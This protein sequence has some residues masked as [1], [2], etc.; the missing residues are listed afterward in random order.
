MQQLTHLS[1]Q[2]VAAGV[3][4]DQPVTIASHVSRDNALSLQTTVRS[5]AADCSVA[6]LSN[7]AVIMISLPKS[8]AI[9]QHEDKLRRPAIAVLSAWICP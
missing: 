9:G 4:P 2:L 7:P 8:E 1:C 5:M 3:A 6:N